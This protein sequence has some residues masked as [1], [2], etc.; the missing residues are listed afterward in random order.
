MC[1]L[2]FFIQLNVLPTSVQH[3]SEFSPLYS[4]CFLWNSPDQ[5]TGVDSRSLL[6]GIFPT[7]GSSPHLL[8]CRRILLS[9]QGVNVCVCACMLGHFSCVQFF[10]CVL[11]GGAQGGRLYT[12]CPLSRVSPGHLGWGVG[13]GDA[14]LRL[15]MKKPQM[16]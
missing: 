12:V 2:T 1:Q 5:N 3:L 15:H 7:Q 11:G 8:H 13:W 6:Q 10:V 16:A 14:G 9:R 4:L